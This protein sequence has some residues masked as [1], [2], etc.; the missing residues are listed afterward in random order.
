MRQRPGEAT[1]KHLGHGPCDTLTR[2]QP[3]ATA[4][5]ELAVVHATCATLLAAMSVPAARVR[6][7]GISLHKL[8]PEGAAGATAPA[9]NDI[10]A[11]FRAAA[12]RP[13]I[14]VA[15]ADDVGGHD[16]D[17]EHTGRKRRRPSDADRSSPPLQATP[18]RWDAAVLNEL[19]A[20]VI[21]VRRLRKRVSSGAKCT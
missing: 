5:A 19:P 8:S 14:V 6:G 7:V 20:D 16:S 2:T 18:S 13:P 4:T 10:A 17:E 21:E 9:R 12:S 3:L 11:M 1:W 15:D